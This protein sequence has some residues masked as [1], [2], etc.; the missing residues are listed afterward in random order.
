[1]GRSP[2]DFFYLLPTSKLI[3][4]SFCTSLVSN[5]SSLTNNNGVSLLLHTAPN[6]FVKLLTIVKV[7]QRLVHGEAGV[8]SSFI[9]QS[10]DSWGNNRWE[11]Q[12]QDIFSVRI[13][14]PSVSPLVASQSPHFAE[15]INPPTCNIHTHCV[16]DS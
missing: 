15:P 1:M 3:I 10:K 12:T 6:S 5:L 16:V 4:N 2:S 11:N 13:Y 14:Q 8:E 9:I 7:L